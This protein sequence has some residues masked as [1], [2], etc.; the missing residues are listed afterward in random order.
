MQWRSVEESRSCASRL[1]PS[2]R[3]CASS[4]DGCHSFE[5]GTTLTVFDLCT[6]KLSSARLFCSGVMSGGGCTLF[7]SHDEESL[8]CAKR[9]SVPSVFVRSTPCPSSFHGYLAP[10]TS[11]RF[12]SLVLCLT[13]EKALLG[14]DPEVCESPS[15]FHLLRSSVF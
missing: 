13:L 11:N 12:R 14:S 4:K 10:S 6:L 2:T 5:L 1:S 3:F 7:V 8:M 9:Y 15:W